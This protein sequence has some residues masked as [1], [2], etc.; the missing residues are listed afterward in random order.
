MPAPPIMP[1]VQTPPL[2]T[3]GG[4]S[5]GGWGSGGSSS[6][7]I[8]DRD[9][10]KQ[11]MLPP[12]LKFAIA[13]G[14]VGAVAEGLYKVSPTGAYMFILVVIFGFAAVGS[15]LNNLNNFFTS[16]RSIGT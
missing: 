5:S 8:D 1:P 16:V 13:L 9:P 15:N 7:S 11:V 12:W 14:V 2:P 6:G 4:S 10:S 3:G